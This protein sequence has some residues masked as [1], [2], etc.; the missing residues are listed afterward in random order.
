[1]R[2]GKILGALDEVGVGETG[3]STEGRVEISLRSTEGDT[4]GKVDGARLG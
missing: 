4:D 2:L 3:G 1:M